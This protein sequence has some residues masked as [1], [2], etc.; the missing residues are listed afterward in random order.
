MSDEQT[1][2]PY[3]LEPFIMEGGPD[4]DII[5]NV[6]A[7]PVIVISDLAESIRLLGE[8]IGA[9]QRLMATIELPGKA[10]DE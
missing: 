5:F 10:K 4:L 2:R 3:E 8:V 9:V 6:D 1:R 7:A